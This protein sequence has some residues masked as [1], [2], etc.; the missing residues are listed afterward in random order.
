MLCLFAMSMRMAR[1]EHS[2]RVSQKRP[3]MRCSRI[4][5]WMSAGAEPQQDPVL[6]RHMF[7]VVRRMSSLQVSDVVRGIA[8]SM[9]TMA[10]APHQGPDD[11]DR[12]R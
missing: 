12:R 3:R 1:T 4:V 2:G 10:H 9:S 11:P 5:R 7:R 6:Q 8:G